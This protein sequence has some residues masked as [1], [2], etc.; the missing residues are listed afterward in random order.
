MKVID[1]FGN[2]LF[3]TL[4]AN[5]VILKFIGTWSLSRWKMGFWIKRDY[6]D[7]DQSWKFPNQTYVK[8]MRIYTVFK[9]G[10]ND[11]KNPED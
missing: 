9:K 2:F 5:D 3:K 6:F 8:K 4:F 11:K 10:I 7:R 1:F